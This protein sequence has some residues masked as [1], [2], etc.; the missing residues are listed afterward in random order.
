MQGV[1]AVII[2]PVPAYVAFPSVC[3]L[4]DSQCFVTRFVWQEEGP[5]DIVLPFRRSA[6]TLHIVLLDWRGGPGACVKL[7]MA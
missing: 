5:D 4:R 6:Q 3:P 7:E 2:P 1:S